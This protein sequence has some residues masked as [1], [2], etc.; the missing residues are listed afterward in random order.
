MFKSLKTKIDHI[1][2]NHSAY[3]IGGCIG[4]VLGALIF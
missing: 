2:L 3:I 4:F 1:W